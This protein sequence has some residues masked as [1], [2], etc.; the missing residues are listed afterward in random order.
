MPHQAGESAFDCCCL[1]VLSVKRAPGEAFLRAPHVLFIGSSSPTPLFPTPLFTSH[2]H[3]T[4]STTTM[5]TTSSG[6]RRPHRLKRE[7]DSPPRPPPPP[8]RGRAVSSAHYVEQPDQLP[9]DDCCRNWYRKAG[10]FPN[11]EFCPRCW[12]RWTS[13]PPD[14]R[15]EVFRFCTNR[16]EAC[17][18]DASQQ[19]LG[20]VRMTMT[21]ENADTNICF[22]HAL[23]FSA[24][25]GT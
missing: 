19:H 18:R 3:L 13:H 25:R 23:G 9:S 21:L 2:Q 10:R 7:G 17:P 14:V 4:T 16:C 11:Y 15:R 12:R 8:R 1:G 24:L 5:A 22:S 20:G 6:S